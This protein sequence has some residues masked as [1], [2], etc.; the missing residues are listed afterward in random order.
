MLKTTSRR[1][2]AEIALALLTVI[3]LAVGLYAAAFRLMPH[4]Y[5]FGAVW[6]SYLEEPRDTADVLFFGS[7][8]C[9]CDV[10]PA[11]IYRESGLTSFVMAGPE[12]TPEVMLCYVREACRTQ[13][14]Q[15]VVAEITGAFFD[16]YTGYSKV[17]VGYMPFSVNRVRAGLACEEGMLRLA[18]F[19]IYD[20]HSE[21]LAPQ[22]ARSELTEDDGRMLC[23]YTLLTDTASELTPGDRDGLHLPGT[24]A[25]EAHAQALEQLVSFCR[26]E[27]IEL[28]CYFSP[29]VS[30]VPDDARR[31]LIER[32]AAAGCENVWDL[33]DAAA[34]MGVDDAADWYDNLHFN[35][36][37]AEKFSADLAARLTALGVTP[38][39]R[40]DETLWQ[41]RVDYLFPKN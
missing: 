33:T 22:L 31:T 36:F 32:L 41:R 23:G 19:P 12:Q 16:R 6:E 3:A 28:V 4:R 24:E 40:A 27:G 37:G 9:Y 13:R 2:L 21:L 35:R 26:D 5:D 38:S 30:R 10:M 14:P 39:G 29:A 15:C 20:F 25:Y 18:L 7:S 8:I 34:S 1:A 17:N 11:A